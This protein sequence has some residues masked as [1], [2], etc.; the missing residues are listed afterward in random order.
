MPGGPT[1]IAVDTNNVVY[2][3]LDLPGGLA[4]GDGTFLPDTVALGVHALNLA[5]DD[6]SVYWTDQSTGTVWKAQK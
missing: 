2:V 4:R 3:G 6:T 5:V 1:S